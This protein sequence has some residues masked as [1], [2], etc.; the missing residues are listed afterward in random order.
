MGVQRQQAGR[1]RFRSD[2]GFTMV[3]LLVALSVMAVIMSAILPVYSTIA[4]RERETEL[5]FRGQQY[6]R[7]VALFQRKYGNALPPSIDVLLEQ[8]F[9]RMK[10]KDPITGDDFQVVGPGSPELAFALNATPTAGGQP[11]RQ[12]QQGQQGQQQGRGAQPFGMSQSAAVTAFGA[13]TGRSAAP[14]QAPGGVLGVVSKSP[15]TS[16]RLY[17]G[18]DKYNEWVFLATQMSVAAGTGGRAGRA[19][20]AGGAAGR[21]GNQPQDGRGRGGAGGR[22][23]G[24]GQQPFGGPQQPFGGPQQPFG[25]GQPQG[26]RGGRF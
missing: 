10:Y 14:G 24:G 1:S 17:N 11:G 4:K 26:P 12:G 9:L 15:Q 19:G 2:R 21:G 18:H 7:A 13:Q 6:A 5:V 25:G 3:A 22:G 23:P 16:L 20:G 8:K